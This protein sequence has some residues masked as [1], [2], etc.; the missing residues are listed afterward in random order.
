[1]KRNIHLKYPILDTNELPVSIKETNNNILWA[2]LKSTKCQLIESGH[3]QARCSSNICIIQRPTGLGQISSFT[4]NPLNS[5]T[6][7]LK[8]EYSG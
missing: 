4:Y 2:T 7:K 1:M 5:T 3:W 6:L 8:R